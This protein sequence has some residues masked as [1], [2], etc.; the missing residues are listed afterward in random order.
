LT[1]KAD[2]SLL[3]LRT[4]TDLEAEGWVKVRSVEKGGRCKVEGWMVEDGGWK[5][6]DGRG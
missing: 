3:S 2:G 5:V 6:K 1:C 4:E